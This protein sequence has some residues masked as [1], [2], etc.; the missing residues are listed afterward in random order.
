MNTGRGS[1]EKP[2][3][4][5]ALNSGGSCNGRAFLIDPPLIDSE[6]NILWMRE[7]FSGAYSP[8]WGRIQLQNGQS[9]R[10]LTF[11]VNRRHSRYL[12]NPTLEET[13][14]RICQGAGHLGTSLEYLE[15]TVAHLDEI[16][17]KDAYLHNLLK[18]VRESRS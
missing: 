1:E 17:V 9:V 7:M 2:G 12:H 3:I 6:T 11:V 4:M 10:G 14:K 15:N 5:L 16:N 18:H 8:Y 13:V